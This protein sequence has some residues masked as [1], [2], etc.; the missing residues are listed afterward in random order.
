M[1]SIRRTL[2][3][4]ILGALSA[5]ALLVVLVSYLVTLEEMH[6]VFDAE[7]KNI[8]EGV[9]RYQRARGIEETVIRVP[10]R[11]AQQ[12]LGLKGRCLAAA[13]ELRDRELGWPDHPNPLQLMKARRKVLRRL[14]SLT[15][16][17]RIAILAGL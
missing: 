9:A 11:L 6:E 4:W 5:G 7:L 15:H 1:R 13:L 12:V 16:V 8:A 10:A 17:C 3:L 2:S 14:A